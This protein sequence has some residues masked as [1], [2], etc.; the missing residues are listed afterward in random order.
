MTDISTDY[1]RLRRAT[2]WTVAGGVVLPWLSLPAAVTN[3]VQPAVWQ[4]VAAAIVV[5]AFTFFYVRGARIMVQGEYARREVIITGVLAA[6]SFVLLREQFVAGAMAVVAWAALAVLRVSRITA[7][8]IGL[9]AAAVCVALMPMGVVFYVLMIGLVAWLSRFQFWFWTMVKAAHDGRDAKAKLAV[10]EERLRFSRD[11][12]DVVGHSL[13]AIAVKSELAA[14]L[15]TGEAAKE[16]MEVR[17]LA[18]ESLKE[19]RAVVRG[20]R[21]VDLN[22][23]LLSVR[24]VMEAAGISC[25]LELP[26]D[27]LSEE[28]STLLAWLVRES[29]TN[30]L[31]HSAATTCRIK[32]VTGSGAVELTVANN[33]PKPAKGTA[34]TGLAGMS[35]R[36][37]AL[38]GVLTAGESEGQFVVRARIPT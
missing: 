29:S 26:D 9:G 37:A 27:A 19:I 8:L 6:L 7:V 23:E 1:E 34:G 16:M 15:A 21:T 2:L 25:A 18:R 33:H 22:A 11:M 14:R 20:Y 12:H 17:R 28:T 35:E 4:L 30:V 10:T 5:I 31:R 38:G 32:V 3:R 24:A 13:S 36:V